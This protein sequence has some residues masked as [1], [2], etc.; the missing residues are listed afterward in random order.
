MWPPLLLR[1]NEIVDELVSDSILKRLLGSFSGG[2]ILCVVDYLAQ[3]Q[4]GMLIVIATKYSPLWF[5]GFL[6]GLILEFIVFWAVF[7][8]TPSSSSLRCLAPYT[9]TEKP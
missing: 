2:M 4:S 9:V 6:V 1:A 3:I 8:R 5:A 7:F